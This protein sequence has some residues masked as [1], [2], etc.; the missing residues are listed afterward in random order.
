MY[1]SGYGAASRIFLLMYQA[2]Y[3][4]SGA[5]YGG[6]ADKAAEG[7]DKHGEKCPFYAA[8]LA[9]NRYHGGGA[10][11]VHKGEYKHTDG[12]YGRPAVCRQNFPKL[13][14]TAHIRKSAL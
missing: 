14:D 10:G 12:G 8:G 7:G 9:V 6:A 1:A 2:V 5:V 3:Q 13:Y 4:G 11:P